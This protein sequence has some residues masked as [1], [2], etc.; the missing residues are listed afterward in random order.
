M[1]WITLVG[2]VAGIC[3]TLA[4]VPQVLQVYRSR[5]AK[6]I[7]LG[8]YA[9]FLSGVVL[10]L[11]YGVMIDAMPIIV[12][13]AVTMILAGAVLLAKLRFG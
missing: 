11:I 6:D 9:I 13:N 12:A 7:S 3:T 1:N 8:M 10:W 5:S 4:F 2:M